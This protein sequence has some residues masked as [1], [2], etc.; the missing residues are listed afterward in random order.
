MMLQLSLWTSSDSFLPLPE[1]LD[2]YYLDRRFP[3]E[4]DFFS[5][6][7]EQA[8]IAFSLWPKGNYSLELSLFSYNLKNK[9]FIFIINFENNASVFLN[10]YS[11]YNLVRKVY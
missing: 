10:N 6:V 2:R 5:V 11:V 1:P 7:V 9:E 3:E 4:H 8:N